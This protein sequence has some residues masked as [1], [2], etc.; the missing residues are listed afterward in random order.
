MKTLIF[1]GIALLPILAKAQLT[2]YKASNGITY[3]LRDTVRLG[4]G[5]AAKGEF[6]YVEERGIPMPGHTHYL[7]KGYTN[8]GVIIKSIK[9]TRVSG[10]EKYLFI[11]ETDGP[12]NCSLYIDDAILA[13]EVTPC[14]QTS[15]K[16]T[17]SVADELKK[18]KELLDSGTLTQ[19]EFDAQ[20]KKLLNQ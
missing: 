11:V 12:F 17:A 3:H 20:K 16:Q 18:L 13:C 2:E 5:T 14:V 1:I 7:S 15:P 9:T 10:I 19:A 4:K 6:L 8:G